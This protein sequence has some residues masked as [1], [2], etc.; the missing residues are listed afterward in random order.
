MLIEFMIK[1]FR[2]D[3]RWRAQS[4]IRL[5]LSRAKRYGIRGKYQNVTLSTII[6]IMYRA[7]ETGRFRLVQYLDDF[8][9]RR[10]SRNDTAAKWSKILSP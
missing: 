8:R 1:L 10:V 7:T 9:R 4:I 6:I 5:V 3:Y 2:R